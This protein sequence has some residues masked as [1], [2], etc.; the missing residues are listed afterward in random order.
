MCRSICPRPESKQERSDNPEAQKQTPGDKTAERSSRHPACSPP[1]SPVP[2]NPS[3]AKQDARAHLRLPPH[4]P[5]EAAQSLPS[6]LWQNRPDTIAE[7]R[8]GRVRA[9]EEKQE[10]EAGKPDA[11]ASH[12]RAPGQ[13]SGGKVCKESPTSPFLLALWALGGETVPAQSGLGSQQQ[14]LACRSRTRKPRSPPRSPSSAGRTFCPSLLK[15]AL[16]RQHRNPPV[17][18]A[19]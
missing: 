1:R 12:L 11:P 19:K 5:A 18:K 7:G 9:S 17:Q 8:P 13:G 3:D 6:L 16:K 14:T 4:G 15:A 10:R 2:G